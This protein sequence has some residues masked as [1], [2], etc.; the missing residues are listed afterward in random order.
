MSHVQIQL[1]S[2]LRKIAG[3]FLACILSAFVIYVLSPA[4]L[5]DI[6]LALRHPEDEF[7]TYFEIGSFVWWVLVGLFVVS[8]FLQKLVNSFR[9]SLLPIVIDTFNAGKQ[10]KRKARLPAECD[11]QK[12]EQQSATPQPREQAKFNQEYQAWRSQISAHLLENSESSKLTHL[13]APSFL[14]RADTGCICCN[15]HVIASSRA[16]QQFYSRANLSDEEFELDRVNWDTL[17]EESKSKYTSFKISLVRGRL[18]FLTRGSKA[19]QP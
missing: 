5:N 6:K 15:P 13:S 9:S 10:D 4:I 14:V 19:E 18:E 3:S 2:A 1:G 12:T 16:L 8:V 11:E 7:A 17:A